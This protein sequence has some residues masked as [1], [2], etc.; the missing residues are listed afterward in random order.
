MKFIFRRGILAF[1]HY[2]L[3]S[4]NLKQF[5]LRSFLFGEAVA[6]YKCNEWTY[7]VGSN[8]IVAKSNN[9]AAKT[10][11]TINEKR[12]KVYQTIRANDAVIILTNIGGIELKNGEAI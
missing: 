9:K 3:K 8:K 7:F 2:S 5:D 11:F 6:I 12:L 4:K 1:F 10:A